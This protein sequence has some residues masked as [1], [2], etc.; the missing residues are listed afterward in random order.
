MQSLAKA[1]RLIARFLEDQEEFSVTELAVRL[2]MPKSQVSRML[3]TFREAGWVSQNPATRA[4]SIGLQAYAIG[5]RFVNTSR[6]SREAL[7]VLRSTVDR[8]GFT[9]TLSVLYE[10]Q[11]I[12]LLGIEGPAFVEFGSRAGM[13]FPFHA[14]AS[15]KLLAAYIRDRRLDGMIERHGLAPLTPQTIC[16][17]RALKRQLAHVREHGYARSKGERSPGIGALAVPVATPDSPCAAALGIVYPLQRVP[18]EMVDYHVAILHSSA[19]VLSARMGAHDYPF[20]NEGKRAPL[21]GEYVAKDRRA[22]RQ[23]RNSVQ[24]AQR[25]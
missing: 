14:T 1:M 23:H 8:C 4:Y 24:K 25:N 10:D 6:L 13:R 9:A 19:R 22:E 2:S 21:A 17:P 16:E 18:D 3:A 20:G 5:S 15:G 12:Y 7:P 11:P